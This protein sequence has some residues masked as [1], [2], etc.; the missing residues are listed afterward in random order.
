MKRKIKDTNIKSN[1]SKDIDQN[2]KIASNEDFTMKTI[3]CN[4]IK[5]KKLKTRTG[6]KRKT[7]SLENME[8]AIAAVNDG[9]SFRRAAVM[10]GVP[11]PTL[12]RKF[13][14][15]ETLD[16][17]TG[18]PTLLHPDHENE[19]ASWL[20]Y[21]AERGYPANKLELL[22]EVQNYVEELEVENPF[23]ASKPGRH[24]YENFLKRHPEV[25]IGPMRTR[26][27]DE[28]STTDKY[29]QSWFF[30][31]KN[32][33]TKKNLLNVES[34]R[35]FNSDELCIELSP[36]LKKSSS[37]KL[38]QS[39]NSSNKKS[40][41]TLFMY[42][43]DGTQA[44]PLLMYKYRNYV[45]SVIIKNCPGHWGIGLSKTGE[46]KGISYYE[47]ITN[48]FYPWLIKQNV[49]FPIVVYLGK[50]VE[51][52]S[53][54]LVNFCLEK[55]IELIGLPPRFAHLIHPLNIAIFHPFDKVWQK[56]VSQW[57]LQNNVLNLNKEQFPL[58]LKTMLDSLQEED[59]KDGFKA[60]GLVPFDPTIINYEGLKKKKYKIGN[61]KKENEI[62][63][64]SELFHE[65]IH[66]QKFESNLSEDLLN[67]FKKSEYT[68]IWTGDIDKK[69]MFEYWLQIKK[70]ACGNNH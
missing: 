24:W 62:I 39:N 12:F 67:D 10:F 2:K 31:T 26:I 20:R 9:N 19:I 52:V 17:K 30:N 16:V 28:F 51:H 50:H 68:E 64:S 40:V 34:S 55:N 66:L 61:I 57:K 41:T 22:D 45:P 38:D 4:K 36:K 8:K 47:Y 32:Y 58:V 42:S 54:L 46:I 6:S 21:R 65:I 37:I 43:A 48:V 25:P 44:P 11:M 18:H 69:G 7:Y 27:F 5:V 49:N 35:I 3:D 15:P 13:K 14:L 59:I 29:L 70:A 56:F 60:A 23:V 63:R 53:V 1:N 33:L